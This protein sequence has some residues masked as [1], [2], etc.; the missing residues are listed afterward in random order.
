M[1]MIFKSITVQLLILFL[2]SSASAQSFQDIQNERKANYGKY[3]E[4]IKQFIPVGWMPGDLIETRLKNAQGEAGDYLILLIYKSKLGKILVIQNQTTG[5]IKKW[6]SQDQIEAV[7]GEIGDMEELRYPLDINKDGMDEIFVT[8]AISKIPTQGLVHLWIFSW[9]GTQGNLI[10]PKGEKGLSIFT[11]SQ[12]QP[13]ALMDED[14]DGTYEVF[15]QDNK[16]YK[17]DISKKTYAYWK[18][19]EFT[20]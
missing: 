14:E 11:G 9:D 10:S 2:S 5:F 15:A 3:M 20:E 4:K 8:F 19:E 7:D 12:L 18:D 17:W 13:P 1:S 16:I 6:E